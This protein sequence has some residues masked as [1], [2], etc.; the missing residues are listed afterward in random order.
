M[1]ENISSTTRSQKELFVEYLRV[2][3][4]LRLLTHRERRFSDVL[5]PEQES[6]LD[7]TVE[8]DK[9]IREL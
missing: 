9:L 5:K 8:S 4:G 2:K 3:R 7:S 6:H 1:L